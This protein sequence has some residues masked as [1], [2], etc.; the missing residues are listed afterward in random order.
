[1]PNAIA[2]IQEARFDTLNDDLLGELLGEQK[3]PCV[4]IYVPQTRATRDTDG[5]RIAFKDALKAAT[6][7]LNQ[8]YDGDA[9][10]AGII[11]KLAA[12]DHDSGFWAHQYETLAVLASPEKTHFLRLGRP[13]PRTVS[14][15]DSFHVKPLIRVLQSSDRFQILALTQN[16]VHLYEGDR[17]SLDEVQLHTLVPQ[18]IIEAL[19]AQTDDQHLTVAS[20][21]GIRGAAKVH[22]HK[23]NKDE[24]DKDLDRY[25]RAVDKA[26]WEH[27]SRAAGVPMILAADVDYH[28]RFHEV[29][30][31][32][33]LAKD[34]IKLN[35][36]SVDVDEERLL[37]EARDLM[38][39]V[40]HERVDGVLEDLGTA[41]SRQQGGT[42]PDDVAKAAVM[43]RVHT[44][45]LDADKQLGGK[46][47]PDTGDLHRLPIDDPDVDDVFDDIAE[48]VLR[49]DG[50]V[51]VIPTDLHPQKSGIA[52]I[53]R[54]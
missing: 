23:D 31:N 33:N 37:S 49:S 51:L 25:F 32:K 10:A 22:G 26:I 54:Y 48:R 39:P 45:I 5:N 14:V 19:G 6:D 24:R 42:E 27:H 3:S 46:L 18:T 12:L 17:D 29:S 21:G 7:S 13:M 1:M 35:P 16:S 11:A 2:K 47:D 40:R 9:D 41:L 38:R 44:L 52:A 28:H 4:S 20:Y 8:K 53:Y 43:G 15:A 36:D 34:G 30:K 50:R